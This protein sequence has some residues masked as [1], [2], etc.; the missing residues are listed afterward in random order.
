MKLRSQYVALLLCFSSAKEDY[1]QQIHLPVHCLN[2]YG[3]RKT[4]R[5]FDF[6]PNTCAWKIP[7]IF[8]LVLICC[9]W[10]RSIH[11]KTISASSTHAKVS[12]LVPN[13]GYMQWHFV[14]PRNSICC[15]NVCCCVIFFA[16]TTQTRALC[17]ELYLQCVVFLE[18]TLFCWKIGGAYEMIN[19]Y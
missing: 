10:W 7:Q 16:S 2:S 6:L 9:M 11:K 1:T 15:V 17:R 14:A 13:F 19:D 4:L 5:I 18:K 8:F 12:Y 3:E